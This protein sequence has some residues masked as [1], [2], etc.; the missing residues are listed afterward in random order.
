MRPPPDAT[1]YLIPNNFGSQTNSNYSVA[2]EKTEL[3]SPDTCSTLSCNND[4]HNKNFDTIDSHNHVHHDSTSILNP[5]SSY[6][7]DY[8]NQ[9]NPYNSE[10]ILDPNRFNNQ[11]P[12]V[13]YV[14]VNVNN[15]M[16]QNKNI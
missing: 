8:L 15:S 12:S 14:N 7:F 3:L 1:D 16:V 11:N 2:T 9:R 6:N 10:I 13:R 5:N 4:D